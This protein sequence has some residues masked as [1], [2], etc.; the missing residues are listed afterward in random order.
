ML[1]APQP[2]PEIE[3][4]PEAKKEKKTRGLLSTT[5]AAH[6]LG[7]SVPIIRKY[8]NQG[9]IPFIKVGDKLIKYDPADLDAF[10]K[11]SV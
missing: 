1:R 8:R 5:E 6:Y 3:K 10:T 11:K 4:K 7:V 2:T 9:R